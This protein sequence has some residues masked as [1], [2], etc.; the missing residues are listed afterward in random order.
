MGHQMIQKFKLLTRAE[1]R[2]AVF[3]RDKHKCVFCGTPA[4]DAHHIMERRL[5]PDGGY[6]IENGASVCAEHHLQCERT[7]IS[8][9]DVRIACNIQH[10]I[11]PPH[12]YDDHVYDKWGNVILPNGSRLKGELF[13]DESVKKIL[14]DG[15]VIDTFT[16]YVKYSRTYHLPWSESITDDDRVIDSTTIFAGKRVIVTEKMDG[17][18]TSMYTNYIH[19]RS[20]DGRTHPSRDWVKQFWNTISYNI[21]DGYRVCGENLYAKH[22]IEY[23]NLES[24]FMG[25]SVWD[26]KNVCLSWDDTLTWFELLGIVPVKVLYDGIYDEILIRNLYKQ[27]SWDESEGY[28]VRLADQFNYGDFRHSVAKFVRKNHVQTVKHWMYGQPIVKNN[29]RSS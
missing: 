11:I 15:G 14:T 2:D 9:E 4:Q 12:L 26:D 25:F 17:E 3:A 1:F 21:P 20:I 29:L 13:N 28:V 18:N 24:Y 19:A 22:S 5:W 10:K 16:D 23:S 8:V 6:Y 27:M 7:T